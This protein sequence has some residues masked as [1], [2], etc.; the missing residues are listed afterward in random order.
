MGIDLKILPV[1]F[2]GQW[3]C[4]DMLELPKNY[5]L[6]DKINELPQQ[7]IPEPLSCFLSR[8][9]EGNTCYGDIDETPYGK[10]ITYTTAGAL[11]SLKDHEGVKNNWRKR[12][13]W[14]YLAE[15]PEDWPICLYWH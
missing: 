8:D 9:D 11:L 1:M 4:P 14:A 6:W 13:A 3:F 15:L 2:K 5:D 7:P 12:A 10:R